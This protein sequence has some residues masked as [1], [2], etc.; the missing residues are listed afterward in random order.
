MH[1]IFTV[2]GIV[3]QSSRDVGEITQFAFDYTF[4]LNIVFAL[5]AGAMIW[6]HRRHTKAHGHMDH[7]MAGDS[8]TKRVIALSAAGILVSGS[9]LKILSGI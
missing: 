6:L 8:K 4:Y 1:A 9:L 7:D 3:P 2:F 5:V